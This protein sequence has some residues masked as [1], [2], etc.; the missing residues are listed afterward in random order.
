MLVNNHF[1]MSFYITIGFIYL[2][3]TRLTTIEKMAVD[4]STGVESFFFLSY[5]HRNVATSVG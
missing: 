5:S 2:S 3:L 4:S 1:A